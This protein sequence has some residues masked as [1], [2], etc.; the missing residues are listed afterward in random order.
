MN[1]SREENE[2]KKEHQQLI[3]GSKSKREL[4]TVIVGLMVVLG[5]KFAEIVR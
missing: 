3:L 5:T 4:V 2:I 1:N